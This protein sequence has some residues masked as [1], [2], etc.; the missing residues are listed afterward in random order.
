ME[1]DAIHPIRSLGEC[2]NDEV[3]VLLAP[4]PHLLVRMN[5]GTDIIHDVFLLSTLVMK[6]NAESR[7]RLEGRLYVDLGSTRDTDV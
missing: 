3:P 6:G 4:S 2:L 5:N 7:Q 1:E